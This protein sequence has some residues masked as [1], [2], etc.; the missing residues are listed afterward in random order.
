MK[1]VLQY[2]GYVAS[3]QFSNKDE[4]FYGK[5]LGVGDLVSFEGSSE[6]ELKSSF[7]EAVDDYLETCKQI[8]KQF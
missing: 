5:I 4:V 2:K 6:A 8:G 7:I 1:E 3:I